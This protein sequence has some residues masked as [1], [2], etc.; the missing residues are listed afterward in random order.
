MLNAAVDIR[1][2]NNNVVEVE[3]VEVEQLIE[4]K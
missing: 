1:T 4:T 3:V 2:Q